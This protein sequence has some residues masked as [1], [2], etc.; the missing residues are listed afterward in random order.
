MGQQE[1]YISWI[2]R[3]PPKVAGRAVD[4]LPRNILEEGNAPALRENLE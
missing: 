4:S 1:E 3:N 2:Q